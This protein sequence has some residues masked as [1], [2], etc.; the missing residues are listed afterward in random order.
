GQAILTNVPTAGLKPGT[1]GSGQGW[2]GFSSFTGWAWENHDILDWSFCGSQPAPTAPYITTQPASQTATTGG[3]ANFSV[4]AGG[5]PPLTYQWTFA[6][7]NISG[8]T[9]SSLTLTNI[10]HNQA[11]NY[12]V[13]VSNSVNSI[14]SS[15]AVLTVNYPP[16]TVRVTSVTNMGG[17]TFTVPV[18]LMAN[19]NENALGFSLNFDPAQ[20]SYSSVTL[21]PDAGH[22]TLLVNHSQA[23][24]GVLGIGLSLSSGEALPAGTLNLVEVTFMAAVV[25]NQ[26]STAVN[27][28]GSPVVRQLA[29]VGGNPLPVN[30]VNGRITLTATEFEGD[31]APRPTGDGAVTITDWV[32][33]GR[34]AARLDYP[35]NASEFQRADCAP[36]ATLGD[37]KITVSDWVQAGRYAI[38]LDPLTPVGGP[39]NE[40]PLTAGPAPLIVSGSGGP[41]PLPLSTRQLQVVDATLTAG[42]VGSISI[43]LLAQG[44][45]NA[46]GLSLS[47]D[48]TNFTYAGL[49]LG[50]AAS[51]A[52]LDVNSGQAASG[53][54]ACVLALGTGSNFAAGTD[55]VLKLSLQPATKASGSYQV[56]L[57]D[58]PVLRETADAMGNMLATTYS[59]GTIM[60]N[61]LP[62]LLSIGVSGGNVTL[63]WPGSTSGFVLQECA[64]GLLQGPAAW[65]DVSV[66]PAT[67]NGQNTVSLTAGNGPTFYRLYK[68]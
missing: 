43:N 49:T 32:L 12:A 42:Q 16:A 41:S 58:L 25:T 64:G 51:G 38:G 37:G 40:T 34:F 55:E 6:A 52:T 30:F 62:P 33:I 8:A 65:S 56:A 23:G 29:D 14:T 61:A 27:F 57:S 53:K 50:H 28:A 11:G 4:V 45:E 67:N 60:V 48:S 63:S 17:A 2:V 19:G 66:T 39:T 54:V 26:T 13:V 36:R 15:N 47:F 9:A 31:V 3:T 21:G 46:L 35:T 44:N 5:T 7:S 1:D 24:N 68:P 20:L 10:Q 59:N 18:V 22:A